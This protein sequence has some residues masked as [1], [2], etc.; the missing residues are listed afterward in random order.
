MNKRGRPPQSGVKL[1]V[2]LP[3]ESYKQLEELVSSLHISRTAVVALAIARMHDSDPLVK[4]N[5]VPPKKSRRKGKG[6]ADG[7]DHPSV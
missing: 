3:P 7:N 4:S 2:S 5:G 1:A 6:T